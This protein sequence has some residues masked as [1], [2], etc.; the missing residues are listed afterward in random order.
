V[1]GDDRRRSRCPSWSWLDDLKVRAL[2]GAALS[3]LDA[4]A[5]QWAE[6]SGSTDLI[7][8]ID[9]AFEAVESPRPRLG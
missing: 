7:G 1:A 3:A 5:S 4:A 9:E 6:T 8:L 2:V